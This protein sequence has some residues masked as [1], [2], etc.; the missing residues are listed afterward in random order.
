MM[1]DHVTCFLVEASSQQDFT[2][3][4]K[5]ACAGA[6]SAGSYSSS[7]RCGAKRCVPLFVAVRRKV[8]HGSVPAFAGARRDLFLLSCSVNRCAPPFHLTQTLR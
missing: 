5:T 7:I 3:Q 2:Y 8:F 1:H 6:T 4:D